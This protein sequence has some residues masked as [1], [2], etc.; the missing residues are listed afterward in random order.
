V[1]N[2]FSVEIGHTGGVYFNIDSAPT[3]GT[4]VEVW[5][6]PISVSTDYPIAAVLHGTNWYA[7]LG[8]AKAGGNLVDIS[9]QVWD[10]PGFGSNHYVYAASNLDVGT[11]AAGWFCLTLQAVIGSPNSTFTGWM[12]RG[13]AGSTTLLGTQ[14][15]ANTSFTTSASAVA[16]EVSSISIGYLNS[17]AACDQNVVAAKVYAEATQPSLA[18]LDARSGTMAADTTAWADW[19]LTYTSGAPV[20]ADQSGHSRPITAVGTM[21]QGAVGPLDQ[22]TGTTYTEGLSDSI[23]ESEAVAVL[24]SMS[25]AILDGA[26]VTEYGGPDGG[27][28]GGFFQSNFFQPSFFQV[29]SGSGTTYTEGLADSVTVSDSEVT[30]VVASVPLADTITVLESLSAGSGVIFNSALGETVGVAESGTVGEIANISKIETVSIVESLGIIARNAVGINESVSL[31]DS[32]TGTI[33]G[34]TVAPSLGMNSFAMKSG[35]ATTTLSAPAITTQVSGGTMLV[36]VTRGQWSMAQAPTDNKGNAYTIIQPLQTYPDYVESGAIVYGC[37]NATGGTN[38]I[39]TAGNVGGDECTMFVIAVNNANVINNHQVFVTSN[40]TLTT[41]NS[42]N[43]ST[44]GA[45]TIAVFCFPGGGNGPSTYSANNGFAVL[46]QAVPAPSGWVQG[47]SAARDVATAGTYTTAISYDVAQD[48]FIIAVA[49]QSSLSSYSAPLADSLTLTDA[50]SLLVNFAPGVAELVS[51]SEN[52]SGAATFLQGT[53]ETLNLS[54]SSFVS[55][56]VPTSISDA[57][58]SN[59]ASGVLANFIQGPGEVVSLTD[60]LSPYSIIPIGISDSESEVESLG[61]VSAASVPLNESVSEIESVSVY[62]Q[63]SQALVDSVA[64]IEVVVAGLSYSVPLTDLETFSESISPK[65]NFILGV[66]DSLANS[67]SL[68]TSTVSPIT[69]QESIA[70]LESIQ[71]VIVGTLLLAALSETVNTSESVSN[72]FVGQAVLNETLALVDSLSSIASF[73]VGVSEPVALAEALLAGLSFGVPVAEGVA[74][75]EAVGD[76]GIFAPSITDAMLLNEGVVSGVQFVVNE[77]DSVNSS[78]SLLASSIITIALS[79]GET[80]AEALGLIS[81]MRVQLAET[82]TPVEQVQIVAR[83]ITAVAEALDITERVAATIVGA[84]GFGGRILVNGAWRIVVSA[85]ILVNGSWRQISS[86]YVQKSGAWR[87]ITS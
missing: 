75:S 58:T 43:V 70:S 10:F 80:F 38:H 66:A 15:L 9:L 16:S 85:S 64:A 14:S 55:M 7:H 22:S 24:A 69:L 6:Q 76:R 51:L 84:G 73:I 72:A 20:V 83:T 4:T 34:T 28:V 11:D 8:I 5:V 54:E 40:T 60:L 29:F 18:T 65:L 37:I 68:G 45:G 63:I 50:C 12:R 21:L 31:S 57:I 71:A 33:P 56:M 2:P 46:D 1:A 61:V 26:T 67:E 81:S 47:A 77:T 36:A 87:S 79:E 27:P 17:D 30:G 39:V 86:G 19:S 82:I 52:T 42:P 25:V 35:T 49:V 13:L 3:G 53:P 74:V 41:L 32:V 59:E 44:T 48:G 78:E 23:S 62:S